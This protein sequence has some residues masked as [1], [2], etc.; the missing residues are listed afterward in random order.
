MEKLQ[1]IGNSKV[2]PVIAIVRDNKIIIGFRHY[3]PDKYKTISVW[4]VPGGR[5]DDGESIEATLRREVIEETGITHM[6]ITKFL[7][8][9][10]GAKEGDIVYAFVGNTDQE[11]HLMEPEKFS[12]WKWEEINTILSD[13]FINPQLLDLIKKSLK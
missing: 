6:N 4:T 11:P 2:C 8:E 3:T 13:G 10:P 12:E 5:C 7:G 1:E 9:V